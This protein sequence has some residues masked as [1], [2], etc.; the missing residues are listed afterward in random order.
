MSTVGR[1]ARIRRHPVKSMGGE[2]L[3]EGFIGFPGLYGDRIFAFTSSA[4]R[5]GFPFFNASKQSAMLRYR[6]R[7]RDRDKAARPKN[8]A[9]AES[10]APGAT[11][12]Y[13]D[14]DELMVDVET[15]SGDLVSVDDPALVRELV[16]G[17]GREHSLTLVRSD[18]A[19][20][21]CRPISLISLQTVRQLEAQIGTSIDERRFRAN[22]YMDLESG[23]GF[24][25]DAFV[26]RT[27]RLGSKATISVVERDP[28]CTMITLDPD[29]SESSPEI[30][31]EVVKAHSNMTGVYAAVLV[32]GTVRTGDVIELLS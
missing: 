14:R 22:L 32:E 2:N 1:V 26:G 18:R 23:G 28:R 21:D 29:T 6:P 16:S 7:F 20:T 4:G 17:L 5:K 10:V 12:L 24:G 11:P 9:D 3:Q 15:P 27:L 31:R 13:G 8:L 19:L 25:E 30:L